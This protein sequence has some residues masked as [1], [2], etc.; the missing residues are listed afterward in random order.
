MTHHWI[1]W[2]FK[3]ISDWL[4]VYYQNKQLKE[5]IALLQK[6]LLL[7]TTPEIDVSVRLISSPDPPRRTDIPIVDVVVRNYGGTA[8]ITE[9]VF[10]ISLSDRP[11]NEEKRHIIDTQMPKGKE[12]KFYFYVILQFFNKVLAGNS[13]LKFHYDLH[14]EGA[15]GKPQECKRSYTYYPNKNGFISDK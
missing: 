9:G 4:R 14:F 15:D 7:E 3:Q 6:Q 11:A 10:W 12:E 1:T 8:H 13:V 2:P 5:Q